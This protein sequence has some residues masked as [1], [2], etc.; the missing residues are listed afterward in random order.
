MRGA[1]SRGRLGR[2]AALVAGAFGLAALLFL[3]CHRF[4]NKYTA[5]GVQPVGGVLTLTPQDLADQPRIFLVRDWEIYRGRLLAPEDF[6]GGAPVPD[7]LTFIGQYGGFEGGQ[8]G[9]S[10]HGSATYRLV[11]EL[12]QGSY[13]LELPEIYS[14]YRLYLNGV[15]KKQM[16]QPDPEDFRPRTG[17]STVTVETA[18]RLEMLLAVSDQYYFYSGMVYP[19]AFGL[20]EA[21]SAELNLRFGLRVAAVAAAL[22][23][24]LIALGIRLLARAGREGEL[25][26][27]YALLCLCFVGYIGYPVVKTLAPGGLGWYY[28]ENFCYCA[29][30][31]LVGLIQY[32]ISGWGGR[33][34]AAFALLG[35]FACCCSL[36]V[37]FFLEDNLTLM[38]A[39]SGL[40]KVYTYAAA[41]FLTASTAWGLYQGTTDSTLMA[42]GIGVFDCALVFDRLFPDF[43][44]IRFGWFTELAGGAL[45]ALIGVAMARHVAGQYRERLVLQEQVSH[46]GHM[47]QLQQDY[48]PVLLEK[49]R[50]A[51]A[52]RHDLRHHFLMLRELADQGD[53]TALSAYLDEYDA[54]YLRPGDRS[55]CRHYVVD[56]LLRLYARR[57]AEQ[58]VGFDAG[59]SIPEELPVGNVDLC[60]IISNLLENALEACRPLPPQ[61][62]RVEIG[63]RYQ[64][65]RL[66]IVVDNSFDGWMK[67]SG[68]GLL[69]RK[70]GDA[71]GVGLM[72]VQ[73][74]CARYEGTTRF[75][76]EGE[77]FHSEVQLTAR[78]PAPPA[79]TE[80]GG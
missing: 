9:A 62:R 26:L 18:G 15:L 19:P 8:K 14:A 69:S 45:V 54:A 55:Y 46:A 34:T 39:Y 74:V 80:T 58:G 3:L 61:R 60:V 78:Q 38:L 23:V 22:C 27:L 7:E 68:A 24:G 28:L 77:L 57:A 12:P 64:A 40:I 37:P 1:G 41:L 35:C 76:P 48:Y 20:P 11:L 4:D 33:G 30:F 72:S 56:M 2:R 70:R 29:I 25:I 36:A 10:P 47:L 17:N 73:A 63:V 65:S 32:R 21:V 13:T 44:P 43:E 6:D 59:V 66:S 67:T 71:P 5:A 79:Q 16:G 53:V 42:A 49:E 50:E 75:F 52:A 51:A 31:L